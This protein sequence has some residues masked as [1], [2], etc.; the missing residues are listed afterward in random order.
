MFVLERIKEYAKTGRTALVSDAGSLS[1]VQLDERS[2]AFAAWLTECFDNN[3]APVLIYGQKELDFLPCVFGAL[4]SGRAY[5]PV[6]CVIPPERAMEIAADVA[7]CAVVDFS[8]LG[9]WPDAYILKTGELESILSAT[10]GAEISRENWIKHDATAY[11]LF[12][13]G[14]TGRPKGVPVTAANLAS[15]YHGLLPFMGEEGGVIL[16]QVSY[17]FDVS[18]CSVYAGLSQGMALLSVTR[19][20]SENIGLLFNFLRSSGL[21]IWV[22]TP[23]FAEICVRSKAFTEELMPDLRKFLFCGEILTN[24]LCNQLSE[25]FPKAQI[26]NTYGPT[27][28]TVLVSACYITPEMRADARPVPIG[29]PIDGTELRIE[30]EC[31]EGITADGQS[32]ELLIVGDSVG[33]GYWNRPDLTE[34][35][36]FID[37]TTGKRGYRTGDICNREGGVYYYQSRRDNQI[38]L[39]GH[40]VEIEDIEISLARTP[41][42]AQ[43]AV[44]PAWEDGK[45]QYLTA[46]ILLEQDDG[47]TSLKRSIYIKKH[48]AQILPAYMIPR[49]FIVLESFPLNVNGKV[50]KKALQKRLEGSQ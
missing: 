46:F 3:R 37:P 28:A 50:D 26:L 40:R 38:K 35:R 5:V 34:E 10:P 27:E 12:T 41:N 49:K 23:S 11:I 15:F 30:G 22:S 6:D 33:P 31:G 13:S 17:S 9:N 25:R 16:D 7:P 45:A 19:E 32:G 4:K 29:Y 47:L 14:S 48:A 36:F 1:F 2:D 43:A 21:G 24:K 44:I 8:G 42:I 20:M 39:H 18:G